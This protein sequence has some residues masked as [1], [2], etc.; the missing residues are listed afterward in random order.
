MVKIK[1]QQFHFFNLKFHFLL[2][3]T[4]SILLSVTHDTF[5]TPPLCINSDAWM[6][7]ILVCG[8][9]NRMKMET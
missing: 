6:K 9:G 8:N 7:N 3:F 4:F 5:I 2:S 1:L